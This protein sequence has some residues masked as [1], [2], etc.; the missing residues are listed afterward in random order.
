MKQAV[1][2]CKFLLLLLL[3]TEHILFEDIIVI[4]KKNRLSD[5]A[6][7]TLLKLKD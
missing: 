3:F 7:F 6:I 4:L 2:V 5:F 1:A